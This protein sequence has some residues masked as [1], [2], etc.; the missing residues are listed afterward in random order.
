L[1]SETYLANGELRKSLEAAKE[2][3]VLFKESKDKKGEKIAM[4]V[5]SRLREFEFRV[6]ESAAAGSKMMAIAGGA[7][8][9]NSGAMVE[10]RLNS[11]VVKSTIQEVTKQMVGSK[12]DISVDS[13]LMDIGINSM[14]AVLFRNKLGKEFD[15]I[16]LPTT[17]VFDYPNIAD[18]TAV[19]MEQVNA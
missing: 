14:N 10:S 3:L 7:A 2:G 15:G 6:D 4:E 5:L 17:L 8:A 18:L 19:V 16:D 13:P 11:G 12:E 1:S 9:A